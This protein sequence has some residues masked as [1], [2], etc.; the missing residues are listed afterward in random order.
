MRPFST[1]LGI[2]AVA[3]G[4]CIVE[5]CRRDAAP[6]EQ[7]FVV[8]NAA[9]L[10]RPM[11]AVLDS[12][13][14]RTGTRYAQESASSLELV[15]RL[16]E[17]RSTPDVLALAD[18]ELFPTLLEPRFTTW[19][20]LFGRNRIVLAYTARS[21]F[22]SE[23]DATNWWQ[24][25]SRP[26]V[27]VGRSD[28]N[29]D[30][31]G[32]RTVL[33]WQLS[34][35]HYGVRDLEA[36]M[37]RASPPRNIRPREADQ[38]ALLQAGEL[39]YI[40]TYESLAAMMGLPYVKLPDAVDLGAPADSAGYAQASTRVLGKR[41]SD[42]ITVRGRPILFGVSVPRGAPHAAAADRFVAYLLSPEGRRILRRTHFDALDTPAFVGRSIPPL[43]AAAAE[44]ARAGPATP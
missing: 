29:A 15:R 23:I 9:S 14:L 33:V 26:G 2:A 6:A 31:S 17:L 16:T 24:I 37:L 41:A 22:A 1:A 20:A 40:W 42:T 27:Q 13:A 30:P 38:V 4:L 32:Y 35:R 8:Y 3:A 11:R 43:V 7:P 28:P 19:H 25:L 34:A 12:F 36:R 10:T 44:R 18:P 39:D 21:R 5:A